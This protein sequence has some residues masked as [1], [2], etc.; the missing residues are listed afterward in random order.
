MKGSEIIVKFFESKGIETAFVLTGGCIVHFIDSIAHSPTIKYIPMLHEQSAAMAADAYAR[1]TNRAG[2]V[3]TTSGPGATNL[4]TGICCSYYDSIP[5]IAITGQVS[6]GFLK[7]D[8]PTRQMGFQETDVISIFKSVTKYAVQV[9]EKENLIDELNIAY[10]FATTGR[11]GPVLLDICEDV[12]YGEVYDNLASLSKIRTEDKG[13]KDG[14]FYYNKILS[15]VNSASRPALIIGA[16]ANEVE[17]SML[18]ILV[19]KLSVPVLLTWGAYGL[20]P[21]LGQYYAGGFGVT[22]ARSGNFIVQNCDLIIGLGT[23]FDTHEIGN[24]VEDFAPMA[25]RIIIDIDPGELLKLKQIGFKI[26]LEMC[27]DASEFVSGMIRSLNNFQSKDLSAWFNL[28]NQWHI[29]YPICN[30]QHRNQAKAVNPYYFFECLSKALPRDVSIVTD[31]G[32]NLIWT[33]QGLTLK[34]GQSVIS[35]FNHSPMGYSLPAAIGSA[36]ALKNLKPTI[37]IIGDGGLQINIQELATIRKHMLNIKIFV[38]NNHCHGIIQGT[39]SAWLDG[40]FHASSPESGKLPDPDP[41]EIA[42]AYGLRIGQ[43]SSHK[44][45]QEKISCLINT[46]DEPRLISVEMLHK[47]QIEPKLMFGRRLEDSHPLLSK[48]EIASNM[49]TQ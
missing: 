3:A 24:K 20:S 48:E 32:S 17:I 38:M 36:F 13:T 12:L 34:K 22:S 14:S 16:G 41:C 6:K 31:C 25:K 11:K 29:K 2:L 10:N 23:R 26:D 28:I 37:C 47:S 27:I 19:S 15:L 7:A 5:V 39:Q 4:L 33:M 45:L 9:S 42:N 35:S 44:A 18:K 46:D 21:E 40:R 1:L 30:D 43:L 49:L 8:M